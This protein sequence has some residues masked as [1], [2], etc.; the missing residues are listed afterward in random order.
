MKEAGKKSLI[1]K[2]SDDIGIIMEDKVGKMHINV[3]YLK[4]PCQY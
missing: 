3:F 1:K 4:V 2:K